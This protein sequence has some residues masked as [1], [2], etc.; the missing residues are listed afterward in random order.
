MANSAVP[1]MCANMS[2]NCPALYRHSRYAGMALEHWRQWPA[3]SSGPP[4]RISRIPLSRRCEESYEVLQFGVT[5]PSFE[6]WHWSLSGQ[7]CQLSQVN[8]PKARQFSR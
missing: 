5:Q 8:L 4:N 6:S 1:D 3:E 7:L 2:T